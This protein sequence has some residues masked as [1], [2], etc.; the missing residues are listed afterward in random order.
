[1]AGSNRST[2]ASGEVPSDP[3]IAYRKPS[4]TE[5]ATPEENNRICFLLTKSDQNFD[6]DSMTSF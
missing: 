6:T 3:P 1:M 2:E 5:T 4:N